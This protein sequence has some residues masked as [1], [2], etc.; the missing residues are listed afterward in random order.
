MLLQTVGPTP[1]PPLGERG[2]GKKMLTCVARVWQRSRGG[3][4]DKQ[5]K[6]PT[7]LLAQIGHNVVRS[8]KMLNLQKHPA[9][10]GNRGLYYENLPMLPAIYRSL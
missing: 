3:A 8:Q 6:S 5:G 10:L 4:V 1:P 2:T 9:I 7:A